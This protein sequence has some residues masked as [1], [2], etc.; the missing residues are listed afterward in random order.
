MNQLNTGNPNDLGP[1]DIDLNMLSEDPFME[2]DLFDEA[3][4]NPDPKKAPIKDNPNSGKGP[5]WESEDNP[6]KKRYSESTTEYQRLND[7]LKDVE[8]FLPIFEVMKE[9][10]G[11]VQHIRSYL[12]NGGVNKSVKEELGLDEDFVFDPNEAVSDPNSISGKVLNQHIDRAVTQRVQQYTKQEREHSNKLLK[13]TENKREAEKWRQERGISEDEFNKM[14]K[15]MSE[16]K[17]N[18]DDAWLLANKEEVLSNAAK[19]GNH[20]RIA[21]MNKARRMPRSAGGIGGE[22][23][24][25][26]IVQDVWDTIVGL[27]EAENIF[28]A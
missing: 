3:Q 6:Y 9:D 18:Y 24:E 13:Q 14:M 7:G 15:T 1:G 16:R 10:S 26:D 23:H 11:L 2:D 12:E 21:Q 25:R 17:I 20:S 19:A 5:N 22:S 4:G 28:G 8:P 27:D